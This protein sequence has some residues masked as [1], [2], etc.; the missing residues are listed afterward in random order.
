MLGG[1]TLITFHCVSLSGLDVGG[2][3]EAGI[4][5]EEFGRVG[6]VDSS[7]CDEDMKADPT[8]EGSWAS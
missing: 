2:P 3:E 5:A 6:T 1:K 7:Y 4:A 8:R